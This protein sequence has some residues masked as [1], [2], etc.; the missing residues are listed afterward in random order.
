MDGRIEL[1]LRPDQLDDIVDAPLAY[2]ADC[3]EDRAILHVLEEN[4]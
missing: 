3:E 4:E 1:R 2:A